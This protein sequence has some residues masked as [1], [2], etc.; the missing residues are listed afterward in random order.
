MFGI[1]VLELILK[2]SPWER[3]FGRRFLKVLGDQ[4]PPRNDM[5]TL[6]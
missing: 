5:E 2:T 3:G 6:Q 4:I 1:C